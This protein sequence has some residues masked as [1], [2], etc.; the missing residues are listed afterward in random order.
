MERG[1]RYWPS[2]VA[3]VDVER[4]ERGRFTYAQMNDRANRLAAWL[5]ANLP[6]SERLGVCWDLCHSAVVGETAGEALAA[7]EQTGVPLGKVQISSALSLPGRL[8]ADRLA[9]LAHAPGF[10]A[11]KVGRAWWRIITRGGEVELPAWQRPVAMLYP[12]GFYAVALAG[13][14]TSAL[15]PRIAPLPE[16][17]RGARPAAS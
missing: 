14:V 4:G 8:D 1:A 16:G 13:Q 10:F 6:D 3:V 12:L 2:A 15:G 9:R 5:R 17:L 7:L 11:R